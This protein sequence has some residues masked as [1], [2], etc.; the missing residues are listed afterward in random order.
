MDDA[1]RVRR[2]YFVAGLGATQFAVP[3]ALDLLRSLRD[4]PDE[5]QSFALSAADPANP[6]GTSLPWP[7]PQ[8]ARIVGATVIIVDGEMTA[9]LARGNRELT[10]HLPDVEPFRSR[11]ARAAAERLTGHGR[12]ARTVLITT[13][14]GEP[15][16]HHP[17]AAHLEAA[18]FTRGALGLHL[19]RPAGVAGRVDRLDPP[20]DYD[21]DTGTDDAPMGDGQHDA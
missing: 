12:A 14:N 3:G 7:V 9:Y 1:G 16:S 2:G 15:A 4:A 5:S 20:V 6:Y 21:G 11:R 8:L 10:V 19:P 13:I 17:F 18:G